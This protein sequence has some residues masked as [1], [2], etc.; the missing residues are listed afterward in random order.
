MRYPELNT[1]TC[2]AHHVRTPAM[3]YSQQNLILPSP[4]S[5]FD[6]SI[7]AA[8]PF[9]IRSR[10]IFVTTSIAFFCINANGK[11]M[12][13]PT[14]YYGRRRGRE[15]LQPHNT[16]LTYKV[17]VSLYLVH[18][19]AKRYNCNCYWPMQSHTI[20]PSAGSS[21]TCGLAWDMRADLWCRFTC[22][23]KTP[24]RPCAV[25]AE[26]LR[27]VILLWDKMYGICVLLLSNIP[28]EW[29]TSQDKIW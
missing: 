5:E 10:N 1:L 28:P 17:S 16:S 15:P 27:V 11:H 12:P 13:K 8:Y 7:P 25:A 24:P 21:H 26:K 2:C 19:Y 14:V 23:W 6:L 9:V 3:G 20:L 29:W 18:K 4:C 22:S